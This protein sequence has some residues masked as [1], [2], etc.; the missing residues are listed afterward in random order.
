MDFAVLFEQK[1]AV[2]RLN[3]PAACE[4]GYVKAAAGE[5]QPAP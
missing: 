4:I 1:A 3:Y 2:S 5:A